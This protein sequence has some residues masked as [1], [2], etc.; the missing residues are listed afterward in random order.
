MRSTA[1]K[2]ILCLAAATP[3][4]AREG[5]VHAPEPIAEFNLLP[6]YTLSRDARNVVGPR[7]PAAA[8]P[9]VPFAYVPDP[10]RF[11]GLEATDRLTN[12]AAAEELPTDA[13]TV[14]LWIIDHVNRP[15][16][17]LAAAKGAGSS[18]EDVAW[19]LGYTEG[20]AVFAWG[21]AP[22]H[23]LEVATGPAEFKKYWT[24]LVGVFDGAGTRLFLNGREVASADVPAGPVR[25]EPDAQFEI[26]AYTQHEP[27]MTIGNI[28]HLARLYDEALDARHVRERF[29]AMAG[30]IERGLLYPGLFHFNAGPYL[31]MATQ[32]SISILWETDRRAT[33][34]VRYGTT[35]PLA[36]EAVIDDARTIQEI[37]LTGL[38]PS[39]AYFYRVIAEDDSGATIDS[40]L[41]TFK[42]SVRDDEAVSFAI[43]GDTESRPHINDRIAKLIWDERPDFV[44]NCGDLT[45][46]GREPHKFQWNHEY[47]LG[48]TQLHS[49]LPC[50]PVPGNGE[51][52]LHWYRRYHVLPEPEGYY[53]FRY[54]NAQFFM[55]DSN[56][57]G[58][59]FLPGGEQFEWLARELAESDATW[60]FA[61]HHH[62]VYT[63]DEDDYGDTFTGE[64]SPLGD[65]E[66]RR[67]TD[68]Y[69]K[70]GVDAVFFGHLHTYERSW[71][72]KR[73]EVNLD[74]GVIYVQS[75]GAGG[76]LE[77]FAPTRSWFKHK[78][79]RGHHYCT[80]NIKD[81]VLAFK[82]YGDDGA[83]R[84]TM[85]IRKS[86]EGRNRLAGAADP[87][88]RD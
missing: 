5:E 70:H 42:T 33:A 6:E 56:R 36:R 69:E 75:G 2:M 63:S 86:A 15:I 20:R 40:G 3:G 77:D 60:K 11:Y 22:A 59:D 78:T 74:E 29:A 58:S 80:V 9:V 53:T 39:T 14:E 26:A 10:V 31:N 61:A 23:R 4:L 16:G 7:P 43:I 48:M 68:L 25:Y 76:N 49:R 21:S 18:I 71:P 13:F 51:G 19:A 45:D 82:M 88:G 38:E 83:L 52:D 54:G 17:L 57:R 12:L 1:L 87:D 64:R 50:F 66:V 41:L 34:T 47:F 84:D 62:P 35:T 30:A 37:T 27:S 24:H 46:G 32:D 28:A 44:I 8:S 72:V 79:F 55:L 73:G 67:L 81:D 65:T 85:T